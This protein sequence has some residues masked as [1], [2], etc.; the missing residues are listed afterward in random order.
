[1]K[2]N[3]KLGLIGCGNMGSAILLGLIRQGILPASRAIL[4]DKISGKASALARE[5]GKIAKTR[6]R[7]AVASGN[8]EVVKSAEVILLALKPQDLPEASAEFQ[9][10]FTS[11]H[12]LISIL[13]GTPLSKL[14]KAVGPKPQIV[15]AMPNL[16]AQVGESITAIC[17]ES[18]GAGLVPA[19]KGQAQGLPLRL[20]EIVFSGCGRTV[21]LPE[22]FFDLV[23]AISGSGPA[24]FFLLMELLAREGEVQGLS[25]EIAR[26][27]A[28]Q[29]A[30]GAGQ[31]ARQA[32]VSPEEL[33]KQVTSKGGTTAAALEVF[34]KKGFGEIVSAGIRAALERGR[35][36]GNS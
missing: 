14:R 23:T 16:G 20:A 32:K 9:P 36:L 10:V 24:Y 5:A 3:K 34:E 11:K 18:V 33:R 35:E 29:T 17:V 31:L 19:R 22:K 15:R 12:L 21:I 30:V 4:Y 8:F 7:L 2:L 13:A 27:L 1:M 6:G 25:P 28:V 26:E